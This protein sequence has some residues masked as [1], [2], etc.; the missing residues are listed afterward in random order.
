MAGK[1]PPETPGERF[2]PLVV[3][4][5]GYAGLTVAQ[6]F[7]HRT[8][9]RA[10][11]VVVDRE[12]VHVLRTELYEI[13]R[14][15]AAGR[16]VA[17]WTVPL[18]RALERPNISVR[19]GTVR[20]IDLAARRVQLED[21][22][23]A[24]GALAIALGSE[25]AYYGVPG[26]AEQTHEVYRLSGAVRLAAAVR[27]VE[28][29]SPALP[30]ERRPRFVVVGGGSTG[31]E[32]AAELAT[33]DWAHVTGVA[34]RPP[35]VVLLTGSL[36]FLAGFSPTLIARARTGLRRAGV[37][38]VTG[39]NVRRVD[40]GRVELEDGSVFVCDLTVWCAGLEAPS[41]VRQ[42]PVPHGPGGRI[43]VEPT[44][45]IPGHPGV[46]AIGDAADLRDPESGLRVPGTAQ[47][48][49]AEGRAAAANLVARRRGEALTP[50][51][52]RERGAVVAL[53]IGEAAGAVRQ[54]SL[55]GSPASLLKRLVQRDYA[56]SVERGEPPSLI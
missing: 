26:A 37:S 13:G 32:L 30:G 40:P 43:A 22:E 3:L 49:L 12:P 48:A 8:R 53:G 11:V 19:T 52:Y 15:A 28:A 29:A 42:L 9:D 27:A 10:A 1:M 24:F 33:V 6:Q 47:A 44:L 4:G 25:P 17:P 20:S 23:I 14:L 50:F 41:L 56:R 39:W 38:V 21:G 16:D 5:G 36:P 51:R 35:E 18:A 34:A 46:F 55:G 45:E 54:L 7:A 2:D 31:T